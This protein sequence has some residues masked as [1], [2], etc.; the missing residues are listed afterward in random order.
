MPPEARIAV[1]TNWEEIYRPS[2]F[3]I[4][5]QRSVEEYKKFQIYFSPKNFHGYLDCGFR[6]SG[7]NFR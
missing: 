6:K 4:K 7:E 5:P 2:V 3:W 1:E